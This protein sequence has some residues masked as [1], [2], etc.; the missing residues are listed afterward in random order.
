MDHY[1]GPERDPVVR[2]DTVVVARLKGGRVFSV[3]SMYRIPFLAADVIDNNVSRV[4]RN[5]LRDLPMRRMLSE[6]R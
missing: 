5:V 4:T 1:L 6:E 3:G 2:A